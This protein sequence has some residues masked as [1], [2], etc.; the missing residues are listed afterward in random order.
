MKLFN[1]FR[2]RSIRFK[3]LF[4]FLSLILL[5]IIILVTLGNIKYSRSIEEQSNTNTVQMI[6]QV[7]KN[8]GFYISNMETIIN[9]LSKDPKVIEFFR[10]ESA[11]A[12]KSVEIQWD[13]KKMLK[14]FT[15]V[16]PEIAGILI[17]NEYDIYVSNEMNKITRD[18][19][20]WDVW[21]KQSAAN[22]D[23]IKLFS[24]P[25]GRN[26]V[27][28]LNYSAD[29]VVSITKSVIDPETKKNIGVILI[30]MNLDI[31]QKAIQDITLGKNGFLYIL[32]SNG[33]IVYAPVNPIVFRVKSEWFNNSSS[34]S[35]VKQISDIRYQILFSNSSYTKW[36][37]VGVFSLNETLMD[38]TNIRNYSLV[39]SVLTLLLAIIMTIFFT[40][41]ITRPLGK[42]R[43]LM[44]KAEEGDL[45]VYFNSKYNDE[46][47]QLGNSFNKMIKEIRKLINMVYNEQKSKREAEIKILQAQIK[48]HFLYNTLDTIQWMAQEHGADDVVEIVGA[49]TK[50]FRIGLSKGK[51][52]IKIS[53]ELEHV[54]SYLII[55]KVR[56]EDKLE[57]EI[58]F[59]KEVLDYY[60]LKLTLQPLVE[61][62]IYHGIKAR[63]GTGKITINAKKVGDQLYLS[64]IDNGIGITPE[65]ME[66]IKAMLG[67]QKLEES[68][69]GYG[70]FNV[71]ERIRLSF[72]NEYGLKFTSVYG[73]GTI[74]EISH[75]LVKN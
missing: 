6:R 5:P 68:T 30:D 48:P 24:K 46:V 35:F 42:L 74:I 43:S 16:H 21:Y 36:K 75:P 38:V 14:T 47:G 37:T 57:Y 18:P 63:R 70:T 56:Y 34:N 49:L 72:G 20:S 45:N 69:L 52:M 28:Q 50:L 40:S 2:G 11:S 62:A 17:V 4:Y 58:N 12:K 64:I 27:N 67:G 3:L 73:E 26:I 15:D 44:K 19:L 61:N 29:D 53:E 22:P 7:E 51:E 41:S 54:N 25:I 10:M 60:I 23:S 39:I 71:N 8:V 13:V 9:Y 65:R 66:E 55:Q 32:D 1:I 31:I 59:D 33:D